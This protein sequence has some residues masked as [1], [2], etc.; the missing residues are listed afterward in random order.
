MTL[1]QRVTVVGWLLLAIGF[2]YRICKANDPSHE[3]IATCL[4][5]SAG[6]LTM[7]FLIRRARIPRG[8]A[9]GLSLGL[10]GAAV[11]GLL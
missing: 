4:G 1:Q 6:S 3:S 2:A 7:A 9:I 8:L 11:V 5:F 10:T